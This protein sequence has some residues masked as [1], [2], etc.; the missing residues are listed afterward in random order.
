MY[1]KNYND[2]KC[3]VSMRN[4]FQSLS[5]GKL[6]TTLKFGNVKDTKKRDN[7]YKI[8]DLNLNK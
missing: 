2:K 7:K 6:L 3:S 1:K 4:D 5:D 8:S